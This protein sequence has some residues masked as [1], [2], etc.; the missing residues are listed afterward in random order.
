MATQYATATGADAVI[1]L[2]AP[3]DA[4]KRW[5]IGTM[6][7]SYS[8][9]VTTGRV[10][11]MSGATLVVDVDV[12]AEATR[13]IPPGLPGEVGQGMEVRLYSGGASVVGKLNVLRSWQE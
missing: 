1:T 5:V 13:L 4:T 3:T 6:I 11:V 12:G 2:A 8:G 10:R 7:A 9:T